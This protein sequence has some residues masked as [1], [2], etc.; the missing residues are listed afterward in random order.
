MEQWRDIPGYEGRYQVSD[1][2]RVK[3]LKGTPKILKAGPRNGYPSVVLAVDG[4]KTN[5]TV[6][7]LVAETFIGPRPD[8]MEVMHLD[9]DRLAPTLG[10]LRYGTPS[11]NQAM[12]EQHG[13][14]YRGTDH[15]FNKLTVEQVIEIKRAKRGIRKM[16][17]DL[18]VNRS[19]VNAIRAGRI[20]KSVEITQG[21]Q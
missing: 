10:N 7:S 6:H 13:T 17:R 5:R 19:L 16:A 2:G 15:H 14:T 8:G 3:S 11:E 20:W 9:G 18:G 12:R 1:L 21:V 4:V